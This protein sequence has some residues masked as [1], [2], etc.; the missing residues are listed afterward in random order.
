MANLFNEYNINP[1]IIDM[2]HYYGNID[3]SNEVSQVVSIQCHACKI[4]FYTSIDDYNMHEITNEHII[5]KFLTPK[6]SVNKDF[7][8]QEL[9]SA[10]KFDSIQVNNNKDVKHIEINKSKLLDYSLNFDDN[11]IYNVIIVLLY[12]IANYVLML[13]FCF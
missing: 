2:K 4:E 13:L 12:W 6:R 7:S 11:S 1:S 8:I 10:D 9:V 5:L 3:N